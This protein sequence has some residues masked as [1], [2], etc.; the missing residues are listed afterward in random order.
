MLTYLKISRLAIIDEVEVEFR[1]GFN[2]LTGETGA[3]KSILIGALNLLLGSRFSL[4]IIRTGEEEA[5]VEAVFEIPR[6]AALAV[7]LP[8]DLGDERE[9]ILSRRILR[10]GRSRCSINGNSATVA[11]LTELGRSLVSIFGQHEHRVLL[12]AEEHVEILDRFG[13]LGAVKQSTRDEYEAW[14]KTEKELSEAQRR[15]QGIEQQERE[16]AEALEELSRASLKDGEEDALI[17]ERDTLKKAVQI[18]EKAFEAHQILYSR[19]GSVT[20]SLADVRRAIDYLAAAYPKLAALKENFEDAAYRLEDV[21]LELRDVAENFHSNPQRLESIE[22]RLGLIRRLKKKYGTDVPGLMSHLQSLSREAGSLLEA[23]KEVKDLRAKATKKRQDFLTAAG[24]LSRAR[25]VAAKEFEGAMRNELKDLAMPEAL[26]SVSFTDL[27]ED[28]GTAM[29]LED[30]EFFLASNPGEAS[31]P[32][33]RIASG[34]ELSRIMLAIKALQVE[35][36]G[37]STVIFDEVDTGIGGHTALAVGSRLSRV[38]KRQQVLCVTHLHQ[39]AALADHHLSVRKAVNRGRTCIQVT[40]LNQEERVEE[41][42]R[43]LGAGPDSQ[44]ARDHVRR[45]I[46]GPATEVAG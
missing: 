11:M 9:I 30:V 42:A 35:G 21:A 12:A 14:R 44:S 23:K 13:R 4:D 34:G 8:G 28:K 32:L 6:G 46:N 17:Q 40:A 20:E 39:V 38:S 7:D 16:N 41:L 31:R 27:P 1:E 3:G 43:M 10:T 45:L 18:R 25:K 26:F 29:G 19:S 37:G 24:N 36:G 22:E 15:L 5:L 2:V 33:A